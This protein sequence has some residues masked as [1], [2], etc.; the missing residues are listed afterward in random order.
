MAQFDVYK[1]TN[2]ATAQLFPYLLNIQ[3]DLLSTL[4]T[5][6]VVPLCSDQTP[7][8]HLNPTFVIENITVF[9]STSDMAGIPLSSC[10][11]VVAN[12]EEKRSEIINAL[13]F[14]VSGF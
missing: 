13:D 2:T 1:N 11:H 14:L 6:V 8:T 9:M 5:R 7:I 3:H 4:K 12:L 10:G